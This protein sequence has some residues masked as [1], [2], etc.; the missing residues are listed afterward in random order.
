MARTPTKPA[1]IAQKLVNL[2]LRRLALEDQIKA[3]KA[4]E[5][6]LMELGVARFRATGESYIGFD[7]VGDVKLVKAPIATI[8]SWEAVLA[9]AAKS[10]DAG[11]VHKRVSP[12]AIEKLLFEKV[13]V[14]GVVL[15]HKFALTVNV[16][17]ARKKTETTKTRMTA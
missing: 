2:T 9:W 8:E 15:D 5:G 13:I 11:V 7:G 4:E 10:P 3:L 17:P 16:R 14:P 12:T 6:A 1:T